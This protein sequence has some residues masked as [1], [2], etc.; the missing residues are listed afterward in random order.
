MMRWA[1]HLGKPRVVEIVG[2]TDHDSHRPYIPR[3]LSF[4]RVSAVFTQQLDLAEG[5]FHASCRSTENSGGRFDH[6]PSLAR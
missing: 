5:S 2:D 3:P 6:A 4:D 1:Q